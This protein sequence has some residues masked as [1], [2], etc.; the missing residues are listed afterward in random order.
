MARVAA[1][2]SLR[3]PAGR[4]AAR[5]F[6][7]L[8]GGSRAECGAPECFEVDGVLVGGFEEDSINLEMLDEAPDPAADAVIVFSRHRSEAGKKSLTPSNA[9]TP[10]FFARLL[11]PATSRRLAHASL[12]GHAKKT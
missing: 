3:D 11:L 7:E 8:F 1:A 6:A 9:H 5:A 2:F 12:R 4:G 10:F